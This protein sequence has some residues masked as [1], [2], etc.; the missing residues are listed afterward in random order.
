MTRTGIGDSRSR[1]NGYLA[2]ESGVEI[3]TP[4]LRSPGYS[5]LFRVI[6]GYSSARE[7]PSS[8]HS[9]PIKA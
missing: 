5:G 9:M 8:P 1:A 7:F 6:P 2:C 3:G 4:A